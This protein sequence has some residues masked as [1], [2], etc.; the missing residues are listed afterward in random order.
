M[1]PGIELVSPVYTGRHTKCSLRPKQRVSAGSTMQASFNADLKQDESIGAFICKLKR[2]NIN[3]SNEVTCIQFV[4]IWKIDRFKGFHVVTYLLEHDKSRVWDSDRLM[5]LAKKETLFDIHV[6]IE[7]TWLIHDNRVLKTQVNVTCEEECCKLE[8]TISE[9]SINDDTQRLRYIG[10]NRRV[11]MMMM[12]AIVLTYYSAKPQ[13]TMKVNIYNQC[14]DFRL[15]GGR[16]FSNGA[17][18][19]KEPI[20][21]VDTG[22]MM[23][24]DL[25]HFLSTFE[26]I[27]TY[28]LE[29]KVSSQH[30]FDF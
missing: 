13:P 23:S 4:I 18:W 25:I 20:W 9:T 28:E 10:L 30:I 14:S 29:K 3:D 1:L 17:Y 8:I 7:E 12:L 21:E 26:G 24:A 27:L 19:N 11:L 22:S 15:I 6:P 16:Y 5:E 2:T